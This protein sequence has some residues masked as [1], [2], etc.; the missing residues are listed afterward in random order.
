MRKNV[1]IPSLGKIVTKHPFFFRLI[2]MIIGFILMMYF[3]FQPE[4]TEN[5]STIDRYVKGI[6]TIFG[7]ILGGI[8]LYNAGIIILH[9]LLITELFKCG[10][11]TKAFVNYIGISESSAVLTYSFLTSKNE[12]LVQESIQPYNEKLAELREGDEINI[13][14]DPKNPEQSIWIDLYQ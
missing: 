5:F 3:A 8:L 13:L 7:L 10:I 2:A 11:K 14:Y 6:A 9:A 1:Q 12:E 4:D